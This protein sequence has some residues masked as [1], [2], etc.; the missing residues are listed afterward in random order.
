MVKAETYLQP[1]CVLIDLDNTIYEYEPCHENAMTAVLRHAEHN[2]KIPDTEFR[3]AYEQA[4]LQIKDR[5]GDVAASHNR[6]LYFQRLLE[7]VG[8]GSQP[9][10]A[11][12]LERVYWR[13]FLSKAALLHEVEDFFDDLR[14]AGIPIVCVT[15]LTASVQIRK[16]VYWGLD[17]YTSFMVT[18]EECGRD[19]PDQAI[20]E[21]A[22][23]KIGGVEGAVWMVGDSI[24]K[25]AIGAKRA[26]G[27]QT[28]I[29]RGSTA[30]TASHPSVD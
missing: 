18:S 9:L 24:E 25:D 30:P 17:R 28:F 29:R 16:F 22:L 13:S 21:L 2:L 19:K 14:I 3:S 7:L 15:D 11:L 10:Y 4:R 1:D 8:I 27:A 12:E 26:V 5:L 6:L 20:F 23:A